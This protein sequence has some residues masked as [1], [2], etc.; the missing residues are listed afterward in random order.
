[1]GCGNLQV[2]A[3]ETGEMMRAFWHVM[4]QTV[5]PGTGLFPSSP[6]TLD[7][8]PVG[9]GE[10]FTRPA[11][12]RRNRRLHVLNPPSTSRGVVCACV[13]VCVSV[14]C[15]LRILSGSRAAAVPLTPPPAPSTEV[16]GHVIISLTLFLFLFYIRPPNTNADSAKAGVVPRRSW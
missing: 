10:V 9:A 5:R 6:L 1:V 11:G 7:L 15:H 16:R 13:C 8:H 2:L 3:S 12:W 14:S 4:D